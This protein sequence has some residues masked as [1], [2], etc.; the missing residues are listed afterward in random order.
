MRNDADDDVWKSFSRAQC[1]D[2]GR[3]I[4]LIDAN[5]ERIVNVIDMISIRTHHGIDH[6]VLMPRGNHDRDGSLFTSEADLGEQVRGW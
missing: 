3:R 2:Q 6:V 5:K 1:F 4:I